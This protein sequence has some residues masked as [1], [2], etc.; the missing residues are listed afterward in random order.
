MRSYICANGSVVDIR[1]RA[2]GDAK[3]KYL[4]QVGLPHVLGIGFEPVTRSGLRRSDAITLNQCDI[5][6]SASQVRCSGSGTGASV[7]GLRQRE[8]DL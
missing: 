6:A 1:Y 8:G 3:L 7:R 4:S 5:P 2:T